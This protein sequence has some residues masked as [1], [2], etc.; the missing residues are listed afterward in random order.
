MHLENDKI[1]SKHL[2]KIGYVYLR[3]SSQR[4]L[5]ENTESTM[6]Q[7]GLKQKLID[8]GWPPGQVRIIDEDLGKSGS[9][10]EERS[11]FQAL[12]A[13]VSNGLVGAVACIECSRLSRDSEDWI[14]LT[15]FCAFT[16]TLLIDAD[17]VYDPNDFNDSLLLGLKGTMSAAEL[18]LLKARMFGGL[19]NKAKRGEL[20]TPIPI[21]YIHDGNHIIKDPD[22]EIQKAVDL[23]FD[24]FRRQGSVHR[25]LVHFNKN[26]LKF[27]R[28][29]GKGFGSGET[30]WIPLDYSAVLRLFH[31]P[32]Y[33][34]VYS[35]G[36]KQTVW[37]PEGK[38]QK[39]MPQEDWHVFIKDHHASYIS[40]EEY[41]K[42]ESTIDG[43]RLDTKRK[44][45]NSPP[46]EGP[47]LLQGLVYCGKCGES[48][49]VNYQYRGDRLVPVYRCD[50]ELNKHRRELC[51]SIQG[52]TVDQTISDLLID[53]LTPEAIEQAAN[54]QKVLDNRQ[55]ETITCFQLRVKK[56][57]YDVD[58]ARKRYMSVDP[59]NRLVALQLEAAWNNALEKLSDAKNEYE[60]Q[61]NVI[62]STSKRR[63]YMLMENLSQSFR[64]LFLSDDVSCR[65]KKRMVRYLIEDVT[66]LKN[67]YK[68]LIQ[69]RFRGETTQI[70]Q[71]DSP[72]PVTKR[73]IT[74][75]EVVNFI[76]NAAESHHESEIADLLNNK[77]YTSG[78]GFCFSKVNVR[79]IMRLYSIPNMKKRLM[80]RGY[81]TTKEKAATMGVTPA[82]L[83]QSVF[84]GKYQGA[85]VRVNDRKELLFPPNQ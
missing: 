63:N 50:K 62:E 9:G 11:G 67:D 23:C 13:D 7:Y 36:R 72:L 58:L 18:H 59:A 83:S 12:V 73:W 53:R 28:K 35:Y 75:A 47:S 5:I 45:E 70:I 6:R 76:T 39:K 79:S 2:A 44:R 66:L 48:M 61:V 1:T 77:G 71:I 80:S 31:N 68:I 19:M 69:I 4:Q 17:G 60:H 34:G 52:R 42:N 81:T 20:K 78:K 3:Q 43:N 55:S 33:A 16:N 38:K 51:Q 14:K 37:T 41:E 29:L 24:V 54:V 64:D 49:G 8:F 32:F 22:I 30:D 57:E 27:P 10:S 21:G 26:G 15:K 25:V 82:H 56:C 74:D 65:D 85:Y 46:R 84:L 40:F